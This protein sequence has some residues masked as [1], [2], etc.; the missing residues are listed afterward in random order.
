MKRKTVKNNHAGD[1]LISGGRLNNYKLRTVCFRFRQPSATFFIRKY[2]I[3]E[4]QVT[5]P[6]PN[7]RKK[8]FSGENMWI[9]FQIKKKVQE[10]LGI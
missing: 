10:K 3:N 6:K 9:F 2:L 4:Y 8:V 1:E 7:A 5:N